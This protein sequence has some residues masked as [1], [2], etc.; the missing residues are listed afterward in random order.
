MAMEKA[1]PNLEKIREYEKQL[2]H[3]ENETQKIKTN[4]E[5]ILRWVNSDKITEKDAE[6]QLDTLKQK[7]AKLQ[8][9]RQ[10]IN[11][12]LSNRPNP[13]KIKEAADTISARFLTIRKAKNNKPYTD[14][15]Y[16]EKLSLVE[17]VFSG[18]MPDGRK[19]GVYITWDEK[20]WK[21]AIHG[22]LINKNGLLPMKD[23]EK[24]SRIENG[25]NNVKQQNDLLAVIKNAS[26][27]L[28]TFLL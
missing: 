9:K 13:K 11:D 12:F 14:M 10:Q 28:N 19:M 15:T 3:I 1:I 5:R 16:E 21:Y 7:E 4:R 26:Y 20:G 2:E 17:M 6:N 27:L 24:E 18:K 25:F 23:Y 8:T 22:Q